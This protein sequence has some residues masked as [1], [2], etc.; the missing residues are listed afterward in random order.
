M[1]MELNNRNILNVLHKADFAD[2]H[3]ELLGNQLIK[4]SAL[5]TI[6]TNRHGE[7]SLC[8]IDTISQWLRTDT[9]ASWEML[10]AAVAKVEQY[11]E[12]TANIVR[13]EAGI[14]KAKIPATWLATYA[15]TVQ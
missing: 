11:E 15:C 5:L 2:G 10:A 13:Q 4:R 1:Q 6:R 3:W 14:G 9:K 12:A 7:A 8:M